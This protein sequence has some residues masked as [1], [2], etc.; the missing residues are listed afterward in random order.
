[1]KNLWLV[2]CFLACATSAIS[3]RET[4][5]INDVQDNRAGAYAFTNAT[6]HI[7]YQTT[8]E[9]AVLL[10]R[11]GLIE[12]VGKKLSIPEGYTTVDLKGKHIYPSWID[13]YTDYGLPDPPERTGNPFGGAEKISPQT[14]GAYNANDAIKS[15]FNAAEAFKVDK[16]KAKAF[17]KLGFGTVLS[18]MA[19]G[20][21]RGT[22]MLATLAEEE[23]NQVVLMEKAASHYSFNKGGSSQYYPVSPMGA[24]ALLRQ[25]YLDA[26][27]YGAQNP[28]PFTDQSLEA[29]IGTRDLPRI[30]ETTSW[31]SLRRADK[32]GDEFGEQYIIKGSGDEYQ[33]VD[34]VKNT[35]AALIVPVDFPD[36][37]DVEDPFD[38]RRASLRDMKHW[39]LAPANL[40]VLERSGI[41]FALTTRG[42]SQKKRKD[43]WDHVKKAVEYGVSEEAVLKALTHTPARL[44]G[45]ENRLGSLKPGMI[46]NFLIASDSLFVKK[47][48]IHQNWIQGKPYVLKDPDETDHSGKFK[49]TV[50]ATT[51]DLVVS[52]EPSD[53]SAK[54]P[55][56][57]GDPIKVKA[58][59]DKDMVTLSFS[60]EKGKGAIR[61]SGW[62]DGR[63]WKGNGALADE[64]WI[65]W[66][67]EYLGEP[68]PEEKSEK[69]DDES[70]DSD[71]GEKEDE[72]KS[73]KSPAADLGLTPYPFGPYGRTEAAKAETILIKN[74]T[75][76]TNEADGILANTDV[77]VKDGKIAKIGQNLSARRAREIE[78]SGKHLTSGIIDEH[79]HIAINGVNDVATN[80]SMVRIGDVIDP[81][82]VDIYRNLAGGVVAA[83]LLHGSSNPIGGQ[84]ALIKLRWGALPQ[85]MKIKGADQYI[86]F[87]LGE[88]VKRSFNNDSIR[89]PQTRMGVEQVFLDA[90]SSARDY[91]KKWKAYNALSSNQKA[92]ATQP[93]RDLAMDAMV[94]ILHG[95][96][97]ISCHSYVQSEINMLMKVAERFGFRVNTFTHIL[98]GY[99]LADKMLQHG[100]GASTFSDW[101]AYKW[102][103]WYAIPYNT[104]LMNAVGVVTAV[105]SDSAEM[106]R[107]LN[108]EAAKSVKYGGMSE[109]DALKMVTLNPAKLLHLDDRM[110]SIKVGKDADL[111]LWSDHPLSI[112]AKTEQ[113][114]VDGIVLFDMRRDLELREEIRRERARLIQKMRK[115]KKNGGD[116]KKP[117]PKRREQW[118]CEDILAPFSVWQGMQGEMGGLQ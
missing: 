56:A 96:R 70:G 93:R 33:R 42:L 49:L 82:D 54:I 41:E 78:A 87:A 101:W 24:I 38:A 25:T 3:G 109:Q 11:E 90:F 77:L 114:I 65:D 46:A 50:A 107:R 47:A 45:A 37:L 21:A 44:V 79:S 60:P 14:E 4:F 67:A 62:R 61:L 51:Y 80:S 27:W 81:E 15:H 75:V 35:G 18:F 16:E 72:E 105:N 103:V 57:D 7:D 17:R 113:T 110:G 118:H 117:K 2:F 48:E 12:K 95:E 6:I 111:V 91:E 88:N 108:Q 55:V 73:D 30:F 85:E 86:K 83:Q 28:R 36:A 89:Y 63:N 112:Y 53:F 74:A 69:D 76:W 58:K 31:V 29:W 84:S 66:S 64:T 19:D 94:E 99:K 1:M 5:P 104:T 100:A 9:G 98:E 13:L 32:L 10:I 23:P 106:S 26:A 52:G 68:D 43:F 40:A 39:E 97:F 115:H 102:E 8:M 71:N 20:I 22:S 92:S 59:F 34:A 116:A